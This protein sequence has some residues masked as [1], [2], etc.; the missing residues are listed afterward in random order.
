MMRSIRIAVAA[1][2]AL[3]LAFPCDAEVIGSGHV[4]GNGTAS[5][6]AP[7][8][9]PLIQILKQSGS[10]ISLSGN[11]TVLPTLDATPSNGECPQFD[12]F[13][14]FV[15]ITC[16]TS[17]GGGSGTVA[18]GI[19][20]QYA[21]YAAS[22]NTVVGIQPSCVPIE[23]FGGAANN[24]TDNAPALETAEQEVGCVSF[25]A[26]VYKFNSSVDAALSNNNQSITLVGAGQDVTIFSVAGTGFNFSISSTLAQSVHI[27]DLTIETSANDTGEAINVASS[28]V[29]AL[30][31]MSD[32]TNVTIR[33]DTYASANQCFSIAIAF[34]GVSN[35]NIDGVNLFGCPVGNPLAGGTGVGIVFQGISSTS[36]FAVICNITRSNIDFFEAGIE[37]GSF[38]QGM[39]VSSTNIN[40][41]TVGIETLSGETG[42][43]SQLLITNSEFNSFGNQI[44]TDTAIVGMNISNNLFIMTPDTAALVCEPCSTTT[45]IGNTIAGSGGASEQG[46]VIGNNSGAPIVIAAN[47]FSNLLVGVQT[48]TGATNCSIYGNAYLSVTT[49]AN[50]PAG[51]CSVGSVSD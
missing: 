15:P 48:T 6:A 24:S 51:S 43:L 47:A 2:C 21:G 41:D 26:G 39:T 45:V 17:G 42:L 46:I 8:D 20:G 4:L 13:G 11:T 49:H 7:T 36:T 10:G 25:G 35:V 31:P 33:G 32:V 23:F 19:S 12:S 5:P 50:V 16:P 37:Y 38:V 29:Q 3:L 14:G 9:A 44:V 30:T 27:R 28:S 34:T 1:S 40:F 18:A 22:G